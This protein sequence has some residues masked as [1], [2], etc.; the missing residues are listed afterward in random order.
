MTGFA[1]IHQHIVYG[2]DDGPHTLAGAVEMLHAASRDGVQRIIA[3]P[4]AFPGHRAFD[5]AAYR[6]R[7]AELNG[8][9]AANALPLR[10]YPGAEVYYAEAAIR[11]LQSGEIPTLAGTDFVLVEFARDIG[12]DA[13]YAAAQRLQGAGYQPV[14]AHIERYGCLTQDIRRVAQLRELRA[15]RLQVNCSTVIKRPPF[16]MRRFLKGIFDNNL[17]DYVATDAHNTESRSTRMRACYD[18]LAVRYGASYARRLTG[19]NQAELF[20]HCEPK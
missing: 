10:L 19:D 17:V 16:G 15:I 7:L 4:H 5:L 18:I 11:H 20:V 8:Y 9:C 3:T 12:F 6:E 14:I 13:L 1:D 2:L